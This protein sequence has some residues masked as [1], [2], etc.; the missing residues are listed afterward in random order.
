MFEL[1]RKGKTQFSPITDEEAYAE[2]HERTVLVDTLIHMIQIGPGNVCVTD[3][4]NLLGWIP[5]DTP[6]APEAAP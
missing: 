6:P 4:G 1:Q 3:Y 5:D 2:F